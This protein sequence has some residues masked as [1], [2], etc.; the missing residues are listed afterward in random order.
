MKKLQ[1]LIIAFLISLLICALTSMPAR[2]QTGN[3]SQFVFNTISSPQTAGSAF[4]ITITAKASNGNTITSYTGT[5]TLTASSGTISPTSTT[6]FVAGVW[7]GQVTL[8]QAGTGISISTSGGGKSGTSNSF[9]VNSVALDHFVFN[10]ISSPQTAGS[11]FSITITAKASNGNTVTSYTGRPTLS[12]ST[13]TISPVSYTH[14]RAH[15]T[16]HDL[17][18]RLLLEK[19]KKNINNKK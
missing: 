1:I 18:C 17:V 10:T 5:N 7:T 6:A 9:T 8:S 19:K 3:L 16:R 11:A 13:G 14:L 12:V 4:S 15:E 2:A